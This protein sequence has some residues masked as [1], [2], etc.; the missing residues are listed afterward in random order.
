MKKKFLKIN[1]IRRFCKW[2]DVSSVAV[3]LWDLYN[4]IGKIYLGLEKRQKASEERNKFCLERAKI[5]YSWKPTFSRFGQY[6]MAK[7]L[8]TYVRSRYVRARAK[9]VRDLQRLQ[10][11]RISKTPV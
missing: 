4:P 2:L 1:N 9:K 6:E 3:E 10:G 11:E 7:K 5:R 8:L